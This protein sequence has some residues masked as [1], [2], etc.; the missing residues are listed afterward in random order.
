MLATTNKEIPT[1][2]E[3]SKTHDM[4]TGLT[5]KVRDIFSKS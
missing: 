5:P 3:N 4:S 1:P 2:F